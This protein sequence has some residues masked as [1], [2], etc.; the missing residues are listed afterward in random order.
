[1]H[2]AS[3]TSLDAQHASAAGWIAAQN[4]DGEFISN[5]ARDYPTREDVAETFVPYFAVQSRRDRLQ[6]AMV[7]T[8]LTT[9][10]NRIR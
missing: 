7:E 2:E 10:P 5:Y 4:A 9:I 3:H 6:P 8:I 1:M